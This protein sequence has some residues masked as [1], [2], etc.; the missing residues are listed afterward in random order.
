[1]AKAALSNLL[2]GVGYFYGSSEVALPGG[3]TARSAPAGLLTA[4]PSRPFF[5]RGFMWDEGF[6]QARAALSPCLHSIRRQRA[7]TERAQP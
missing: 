7:C 5:P 2:G 1:V 4:V 6:H 3:R